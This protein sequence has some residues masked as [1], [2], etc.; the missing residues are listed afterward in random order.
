M[1]DQ[2]IKE[3]C[4]R[5]TGEAGFLFIDFNVRGQHSQKII[6]V[7]VDSAKGLSVDDCAVLSRSIAA[8]L[9][10][11]DI[12]AHA[13]R[14][15]VSSPGVDRPL[16]FPAQYPKHT[17]RILELKVRDED[18]SEKEITGKLEAADEN[19]LRLALKDRSELVINFPS[20]ITAKV[21]ISFS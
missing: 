12:I 10:V 16:K 19:E 6:E 4:E 7:F 15:D 20:I 17:G 8:E 11:E 3:I 14:L 18:G 9:E 5:I 1:N 2:K 21:K 13:Y